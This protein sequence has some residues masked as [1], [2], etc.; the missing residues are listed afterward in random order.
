MLVKINDYTSSK[1]YLVTGNKSLLYDTKSGILYFRNNSNR[2]QE[3]PDQ[4]RNL[5]KLKRLLDNYRFDSDFSLDVKERNII[6][7]IQRQINMS[8]KKK[9]TAKNKSKKNT[10]FSFYTF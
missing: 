1:F 9:A 6:K 5:V 2:L 8:R 10:S 3:L 4:N 7:P